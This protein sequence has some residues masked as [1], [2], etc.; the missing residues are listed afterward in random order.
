MINFAI[1]F[2][3]IFVF[4]PLGHFS[5]CCCILFQFVANFSC[6]AFLQQKVHFQISTKFSIKGSLAGQI[7]SVCTDDLTECNVGRTPGR[8]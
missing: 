8:F 1:V 4:L 3:F 5:R 2:I 6:F 7:L